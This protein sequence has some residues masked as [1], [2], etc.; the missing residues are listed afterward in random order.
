MCGRYTS[1]TPADEVARY[2]D[3]DE[4]VLEDDPRPPRWNV[5][6]TDPVLGVAQVGDVRRLGTFRWGLVPHWAE[7]PSVGARM[8]NA[9][10]ETL[11]E[12]AA[13]RRPLARARGIVPADG[14]YEWEARPGRPKQVWYIRR[15]DGGLLAF[16]GLW[17][18][19]RREGAEE[20]VVSCSIITTSANEVLAPIHDRMPVVLAPETWAEWL[21]PAN[22]DVEDLVDLLVPAEADVLE[23]IPVGSAVGNVA[24]DGPELVEPVEPDAAELFPA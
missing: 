2:F 21:D 17:A 6:P 7:G 15:R 9:R 19:W 3:V 1:V 12:K 11:L 24:N 4:V 13:F 16:A 5:A 23:R 20:R 8:I 10:A 18:T 22:Q 14:F